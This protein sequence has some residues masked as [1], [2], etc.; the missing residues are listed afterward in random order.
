[1]LTREQIE[2]MREDFDSGIYWKLCDQAIAAIALRDALLGTANR[3]DG[4]RKICWCVTDLIS[5]RYIGFHSGYCQNAR[6]AL[7]AL[8]AK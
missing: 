2:E 5:G 4:D 6:K 3:M 8:E 1:M 7:A